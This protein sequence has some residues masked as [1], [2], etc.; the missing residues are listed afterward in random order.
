MY[1]EPWFMAVAPLLGPNKLFL[2]SSPLWAD[3]HIQEIASSLH[4]ASFSLLCTTLHFLQVVPPGSGHIGGDAL[5][6]VFCLGPRLGYSV[7]GDISR[8]Y[9]EHSEVFRASVAHV[10]VAKDRKR[11]APMPKISCTTLGPGR[12]SSNVHFQRAN[13]TKMLPRTDRTAG[14]E[15]QSSNVHFQRENSTRTYEI[16]A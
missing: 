1:F 13:S 14:H 16:V 7:E 8:P 3:F 9:R 6:R 15:E 5:L 11:S 10:D 12:H 2:L 4:I